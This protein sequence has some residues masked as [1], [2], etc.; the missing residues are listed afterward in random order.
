M[1]VYR[2]L[3]LPPS[4]SSITRDTFPATHLSSFA[5]P[6]TLDFVLA[7]LNDIANVAAHLHQRGIMHGDLYAHNILVRDEIDPSSTDIQRHYH[8]ILTDFGAAS[9]TKH[10]CI[11]S[12]GPDPVEENQE[13]VRIAFEQIELRAF[14]HLV[15]DLLSH[16]TAIDDRQLEIVD[17]LRELQRDILEQQG[18]GNKDFV[19]FAKAAVIIQGCL[20]KNSEA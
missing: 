11:S 10:L 5:S 2:I 17:E 7:T 20:S 16:I 9:L 13:K 3:G 18:N 4:F 14:A 6:W 8:A 15:D 12:E 19:S 1:L